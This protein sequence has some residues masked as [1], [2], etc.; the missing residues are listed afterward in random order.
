MDMKIC[1]LCKGTGIVRYRSFLTDIDKDN[2]KSCPNCNYGSCSYC[3]GKHVK[4]GTNGLTPCSSC[5]Y[6]D[7][8]D[9]F[10][11]KYRWIKNH[12]VPCS[13]G[14]KTCLNTGKISICGS[15]IVHD[16]IDCSRPKECKYPKTCD[17]AFCIEK[18]KFDQQKNDIF[19]A[20]SKN[21]KRFKHK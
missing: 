13:C 2:F 15:N 17:C 20:S 5:L 6:F 9:C 14:C 11:S 8:S 10:D 7:C 4:I 12:L 3:F 16:C 21:S 19:T 18:K 1:T